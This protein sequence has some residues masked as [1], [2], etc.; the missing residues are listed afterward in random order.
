MTVGHFHKKLLIYELFVKNSDTMFHEHMTKYSV[1]N[2]SPHTDAWTND[3]HGLQIDFF[4]KV[5]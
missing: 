2:T 4:V 3:G 1:T 5:T